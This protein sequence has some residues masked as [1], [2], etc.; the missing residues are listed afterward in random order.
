MGDDV[1]ISNEN[2]AGKGKGVGQEGARGKIFEG[3]RNGATLWASLGLLGL[4]VFIFIHIYIYI[5]IDSYINLLGFFPRLASGF[6]AP[7][8][9]RLLY[10]FVSYT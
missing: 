3:N 9:Y 4:H 5:D 2:P 1:A 7:S 10:L 8:S 6:Q